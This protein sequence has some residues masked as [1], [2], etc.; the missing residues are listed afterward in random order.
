MG[1]AIGTRVAMIRHA[2]WTSDAVG[3]I[4]GYPRERVNSWGKAY[5]DYLIEFDEP[6]S[7]LTDAMNGQPDRRYKLSTVAEEYLR[8][9]DGDLIAADR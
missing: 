6:Q 1:F 7:D 3:T 2:D 8:P 9:M 4:V 5:V